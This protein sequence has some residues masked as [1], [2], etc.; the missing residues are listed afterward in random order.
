MQTVFSQGDVLLDCLPGSLAPKMAAYARE[1]K[2][3]YV[4]LTEYVAETNEIIQLAK[5]AESGFVLQSGLAPGYIDLLAHHLYQEFC[6]N[7]RVDK[8]TALPGVPL[9]WPPNTL[10]MRKP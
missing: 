1:Y 4:N 8:V 9:A 10:R 5:N 7:H 2:L 3:H 6:A